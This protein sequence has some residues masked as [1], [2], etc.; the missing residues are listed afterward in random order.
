MDG[1]GTINETELFVLTKD[2]LSGALIQQL[3]GNYSFSY[4]ALDLL[5]SIQNR[6]VSSVN[7]RLWKTLIYFFIGK[8]FFKL[9]SNLP[10][11]STVNDSILDAFK[12]EKATQ[13]MT[14]LQNTEEVNVTGVSITPMILPSLTPSSN[15]SGAISESPS[16]RP[17]LGPTGSPSGIPSLLPSSR[18]SN[19]PSVSLAPSLSF[20]PSIPPTTSFAPLI[21]VL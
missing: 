20:A 8:V 17:T 16:S 21:Q 11:A 9:N 13:F 10:D 19:S 1:I 14:V 4:L 15:P 2:H 12:D 7:Q 6:R 18:P 3:S 5:Q